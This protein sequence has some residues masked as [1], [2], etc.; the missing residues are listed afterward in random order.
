MPRSFRVPVGRE[1]QLVANKGLKS[2]ACFIRGG[3]SSNVENG[4]AE[5]ITD[6][7]AE[8][9]RHMRDNGNVRGENGSNVRWL[10]RGKKT[11]V[12]GVI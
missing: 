9:N 12:F 2:M 8:A 10:L 3:S 4:I 11:A 5:C 1:V 7:F 6:V